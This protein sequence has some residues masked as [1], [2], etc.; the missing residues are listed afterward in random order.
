[1][2]VCL[3]QPRE[4]ALV[5]PISLLLRPILGPLFALFPSSLKVKVKKKSGDVEATNVVSAADVSA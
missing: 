1:M 5:T 4:N 2:A 3:L